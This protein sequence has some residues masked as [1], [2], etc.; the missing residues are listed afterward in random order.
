MLYN[1]TIVKKNYNTT[2]STSYELVLHGYSEFC[3]KSH[4]HFTDGF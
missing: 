1:G 3:N 4:R 2:T